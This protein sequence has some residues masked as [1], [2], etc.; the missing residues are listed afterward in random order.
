[1][2]TPDLKTY[3]VERAVPSDL[4]RIENLLREAGL[5]T[6]GVS[7]LIARFAVVREEGQVVAAGV[8]EPLDGAGLLRSVVVD[9]T[10]RGQ[11]LGQVVVNHLVSE[12]DVPIFLLTETAPA[13]FASL[14]FEH[15]PRSRAPEA[16]RHT[17]EYC[18]LCAESAALMWRS[19]HANNDQPHS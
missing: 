8:I 6:K 7:P 10:R 5:P 2:E 14:G 13:F 12:A 11:G 1:M 15:L 16:V 4:D 17:Q 19:G 18:S 9:A 3:R